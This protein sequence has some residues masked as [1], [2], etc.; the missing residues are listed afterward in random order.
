MQYN[1]YN[2]TA[3]QVLSTLQKKHNYQVLQYN[4]MHYAIN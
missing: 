2:K 4:L 1:C 3:V